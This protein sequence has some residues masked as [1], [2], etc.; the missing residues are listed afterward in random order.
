MLDDRLLLSNVAPN[1]GVLV[2]RNPLPPGRLG[3]PVHVGHSLTGS[4]A[5]VLGHGR[6]PYPRCSQ[7]TGHLESTQ[8]AIHEDVGQTTGH[9]VQ[10]LRA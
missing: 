3:D 6:E 4:L 5:V 8:T 7:Q 1:S 2:E 10:A 9:Q